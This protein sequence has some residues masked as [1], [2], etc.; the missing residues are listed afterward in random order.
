MNSSKKDHQKGSESATCITLGAN[1]L[2]GRRVDI[3]EQ[4]V[5]VFKKH[6]KY[7]GGH[8]SPRDSMPTTRRASAPVNRKSATCQAPE[9]VLVVSVPG[10]G[11]YEILTAA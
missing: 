10:P 5:E 3:R 1:R 9:H 7:G 6:L 11:A 8:V 4:K 2:H